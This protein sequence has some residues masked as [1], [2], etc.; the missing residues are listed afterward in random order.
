MKG[1]YLNGE[2]KRLHGD[3]ED[4]EKRSLHVFPRNII[5]IPEDLYEE[6]RNK[7]QKRTTAQSLWLG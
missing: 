2:E 6:E 5:M 7:E 1:K 4:E 3:E